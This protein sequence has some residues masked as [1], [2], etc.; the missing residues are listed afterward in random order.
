MVP[1]G[2][3]FNYEPKVFDAIMKLGYPYWDSR[4]AYPLP[5]SVPHYHPMQIVRYPYVVWTQLGME[6]THGTLLP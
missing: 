2:H 5:S 1:Q 6:P 3:V 4:I